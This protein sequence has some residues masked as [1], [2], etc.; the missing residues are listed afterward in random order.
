MLLLDAPIRVGGFNA[1]RDHLDPRAVYVLPPPPVIRSLAL[2]ERELVAELDAHPLVEGLDGSGFRACPMPL[3]AVDVA[4]VRFQARRR[5]GDADGPPVIVVRRLGSAKAPLEAPGRVELRA[6]LEPADHDEVRAA[7]TGAP[8]PFAWVTRL[9]LRGLEPPADIRLRVDARGARRRIASVWPAAGLV[10]SD[11]VGSVVD[12]LLQNGLVELLDGRGADPDG[13]RFVARQVLALL[14]EPEASPGVLGPEALEA[15]GPLEAAWVDGGRAVVGLRLRPEAALPG[16]TTVLDGR[17]GLVRAERLITAARFSASDGAVTR[18]IDPTVAPGLAVHP[19]VDWTG[20]AA[21]LVEV[22]DPHGTR[23]VELRRERPSSLERPR[24]GAE[25]RALAVL[26]PDPGAVVFSEP[27]FTPWV[28]WKGPLRWDPQGLA[29]RRSFRVGLGFLDPAQVSG[30][31]LVLEG[32][33]GRLELHL[34]G[35]RPEVAQRVVGSARVCRARVR[36]AD[37]AVHTEEV[38]TSSGAA[39]VVVQ[40]PASLR[41][42]LLVRLADPTQ[43]YAGA[44]VE[45]EGENGAGRRGFRLSRG[46]PEAIWCPPGDPAAGFRYRVELRFEDGRRRV[47]PWRVGEPGLLRVGDVEAEL[48]SIEVLIE[49]DEPAGGAW[50]VFEAE[51][52]PEG[53]AGPVEAFL[54]LGR[55]TTV[56]VPFRLGAPFR[57]RVFGKWYEAD[58]QVRSFEVESRRDRR[59]VLHHPAG[60]AASKSPASRRT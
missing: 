21:V 9:S 5:R 28:P 18:D 24:P 58:G 54:E 30:A 48:R 51:H 45:V 32:P 7:L 16:E 22:R 1:Y 34:D 8:S 31:D 59:L 29:G 49:G 13:L 42:P 46:A 60:S 27:A 10:F 4:L 11:Q 33:L 3:E 55:P 12:E 38:E 20:V 40:Q 19:D 37:G 56:E 14:F 57:Y 52:A 23:T 6:A 50:L 36:T 35:A 17:R 15:D 43:R 44:F 26:S 25:V 2:G 41:P 39:I 47:E 53:I